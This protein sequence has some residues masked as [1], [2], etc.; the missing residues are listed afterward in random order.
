MDVALDARAIASR[1]R[2]LLGAPGF[3]GRKKA[4]RRLGVAEPVLRRSIDDTAPRPTLELL[5]AVVRDYGVDPSWLL[6]GEYDPATH[7]VSLEAGSEF[8]SHVLRSLAAS[9][10][11]L[12]DIFSP[13]LRLGA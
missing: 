7:R 6:F 4:A 5:A 3:A 2:A 12:D 11:R 8:D 10:L 13:I 9:R 1:L